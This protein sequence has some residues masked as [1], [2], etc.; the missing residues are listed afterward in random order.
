MDREEEYDIAVHVEDRYGN[1]VNIS[2]RVLITASSS[3][4]NDTFEI[5]S[6][7]IVTLYIENGF[8]NFT[9]GIFDGDGDDNA[10]LKIEYDED[11][12][13]YL[14]DIEEVT[15]SGIKIVDP[16]ADIEF[17]EVPEIIPRKQAFD[18]KIQNDTGGNVTLGIVLQSGDPNDKIYDDNSTNVITS[19]T[20]TPGLNTETWK[21]GDGEGIAYGNF[22]LQDSSGAKLYSDEVQITSV[23]KPIS[24]FMVW[25][26]KDGGTKDG[27]DGT[28]CDYT[29]RVKYPGFLKADTTGISDADDGLLG[30]GMSPTKFGSPRQL[31]FYNNLPPEG[32]ALT[33]GQLGWGYFDLGGNFVLYDDGSYPYRTLCS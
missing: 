21:I 23:P 14:E 28:P 2:G 4:Q 22:V 30:T 9:L 26:W 19:V 32:S 8:L 27:S 18:I 12:P 33:E 29:Y 25:L 15:V 13:A 24:L 11:L 10:T 6:Q 1:A 31:G 5:N 7:D 3:D 16:M 17:T 20:L